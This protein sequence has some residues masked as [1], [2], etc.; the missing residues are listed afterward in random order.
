MLKFKNQD[1][2][3]ARFRAL[4]IVDE[5]GRNREKQKKNAEFGKKTLL[6]LSLLPAGQ[7][8]YHH[9]CFQGMKVSRGLTI[10]AIRPCPCRF[11]SAA[12]AGISRRRADFAP[13]RAPCSSR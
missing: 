9:P 12:F 4:Q 3:E 11:F 10:A 6:R 1:A 2:Y 13:W 8:E 5:R 7:H